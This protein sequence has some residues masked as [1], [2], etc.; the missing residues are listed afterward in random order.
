MTVEIRPL[1]WFT[2]SVFALTGA[3]TAAGLI[4]PGVVAALRREPAM[5]FRMEYWRFFSALLVHAGGVRQLV[6]N[7]LALGILDALVE[8]VLGRKLWALSYLAC[9]LVG[10]VTGIFWQPVG[11]GNSVA[12]CGLAG[13]LAIYQMLRHGLAVPARF[14]FPIVVLGGG[15]VLTG[16]ADLHGP[17]LLAGLVIGLIA[18]LIRP[19]RFG[20]GV[21]AVRV[22][23]G[24]KAGAS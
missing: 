12:L 20:N 24:A 5:V 17:P 15:V 19:D 8:R 22:R 2:A 16:F 7:F 10:E 1:P 4:W 21:G 23:T 14:G 18:F 13:L 6:L 11:A 3:V 9:G